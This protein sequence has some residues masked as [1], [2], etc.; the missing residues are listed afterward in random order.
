MCARMASSF[1][2]KISHQHQGLLGP[3]E[4]K[5][6]RGPLALQALLA[7]QVLRGQRVLKDQRVLRDQRVLKAPS[8]E[9]GQDGTVDTSNY[10]NKTQVDFCS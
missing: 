1:V 6:P 4:I 9:D 10:Y 2:W 5:G 3:K 7:R 8:G